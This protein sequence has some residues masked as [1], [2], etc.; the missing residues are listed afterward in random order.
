MAGRDRSGRFA[1]SVDEPAAAEPELVHLTIEP[2]DDPEP[3]FVP[4][5][6]FEPE[7][8]SGD[9][10]DE[11]SATDAMLGTA[12]ARGVDE[13][14]GMM[15]GA[16]YRADAAQVEAV[17]EAAYPVV[18]RALSF[19]HA[20][21]LAESTIPAP[22]RE[23]GTLA[24]RAYAAWGDALTLIV[25]NKISEIREGRNDRATP[26]SAQGADGQPGRHGRANGHADG[27]PAPFPAGAFAGEA[28]RTAGPGVGAPGPLDELLALRSR[29]SLD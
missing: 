1:R 4:P 23:I 26:R 8:P 3:A 17:G 24:A 12:L 25:Q 16:A 7:P 10:T 19:V 9:A 14:V 2:R 15:F 13:L 21:E 29:P 20:A 22:I 18:R 28:D 6:A 27:D 5:L 11:D